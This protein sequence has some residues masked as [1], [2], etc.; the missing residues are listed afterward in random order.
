MN[1]AGERDEVGG[2]GWDG[3]LPTPR[4]H[5][6][7]PATSAPV[8]H[9]SRVEA[10]GGRDRALKRGSRHKG[11][12]RTARQPP[13][14]TVGVVGAAAALRWGQLLAEHDVNRSA[15]PPASGSCGR[16][17]AE[18]PPTRAGG[19]KTTHQHNPVPGPP[20]L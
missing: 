7:L 4:P 14:T 19:V 2:V 12:G 3:R 8:D 11:R 17:P 6:A 10:A 5:L 9:A 16:L 1:D 15:T 18:P 20:K 13:A